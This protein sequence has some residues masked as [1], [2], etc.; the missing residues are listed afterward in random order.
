MPTNQPFLQLMASQLGCV[1][2]DLSRPCRGGHNGTDM[3]PA[4]QWSFDMWA[5]GR[6]KKYNSE[7]STRLQAGDISLIPEVIETHNRVDP[8]PAVAAV[9]MAPE[10]TPL[11]SVR[12]MNTANAASATGVSQTAIATH[13]AEG[14]LNVEFKQVTDDLK[15]KTAQ[16]T[17]MHHD[18]NNILAA[19]DKM[20]EELLGAKRDHQ[21]KLRKVQ[22]GFHGRLLEHTEDITDK[23]KTKFEVETKFLREEVAIQTTV[24][25]GCAIM[26]AKVSEVGPRRALKAIQGEHDIARGRIVILEKQLKESKAKIKTLDNQVHTL[27]SKTQPDAIMLHQYNAKCAEL[28]ALRLRVDCKKLS[29]NAKVTALLEWKKKAE[30]ATET[31]ANEKKEWIHHKTKL[32]ATIEE[33]TKT[34]EKRITRARKEVSS[35]RIEVAK[36]RKENRQ[37][38]M[39]LTSS[40]EYARESNREAITRTNETMAANQ[41]AFDMETEAINLRREVANLKRKASGV[42]SKP[43]KKKKQRATKKQRTEEPK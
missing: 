34:A 42:V 39:D 6:A 21:N 38:S 4:L 9:S 29:K 20:K 11:E 25:D 17:L 22:D 28:E 12:A 41:K 37:L 43:K 19:H 8:R 36:L 13:D 23:M 35:V 2:K 10:G 33:L 14:N 30:T 27:R 32:T 1:V 40:R 24:S 7:T 5:S 3:H 26:M 15:K 18:I 31:H 16:V